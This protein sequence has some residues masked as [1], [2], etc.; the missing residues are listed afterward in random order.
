MPGIQ[1]DELCHRIK[2]NPDTEGIPFILLTA[3]VNHDAV[4]V[5]LKN[6]ADD[7][8][9]KPFSTEILKLKVQGL[10]E[11]R[12]RLRN[13]LMRQSLQQVQNATQKTMT[14]GL[15]EGFASSVHAPKESC[16]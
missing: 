8:I 5:G 12:K 9:P 6:G 10:L 2:L 13:Y 3:K 7:Y 14:T 16:N 1:G 4:V 11:N 15:V